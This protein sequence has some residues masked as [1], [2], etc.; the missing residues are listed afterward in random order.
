MDTNSWITYLNDTDPS[1]YIIYS[2]CPFD[3]CYPQTEKVYMNLNLPNGADAQCDYNRTG[4]LCGAC[5][6][7]LSLSLGSSHCLSCHSH[8]PAVLV[9]ILITFIISGILLVTAL[10]VLNM[11]VAVGLINGFIF[12]AN[13]VSAGSAAVSYTHLTLPTIYSV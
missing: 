9:T 11:T 3:Y 12:Y 10:L 2:N 4:L 5:Q 6:K 1:G 8:W 13:I 7:N